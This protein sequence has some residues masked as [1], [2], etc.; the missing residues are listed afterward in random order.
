MILYFVSF[1]SVLNLI[2]FVGNLILSP[3][4]ASDSSIKE[5]FYYSVVRGIKTIPLLYYTDYVRKDV[6]KFLMENL[7]WKNPG[8]HYFDYL[9]QPLV[10]NVMRTKFNINCRIYNYSALVRSGQMDRGVSLENSQSEYVIEDPQVISLCIKRLGLTQEQFDEIVAN[11]TKIIRDYPN[12]Y[13]LSRVLRPV[14]WLL[15]KMHFISA[16]AYDKHF[17]CGE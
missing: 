13:A 10:T 11:P 1:F 6:D 17:N 16:S 9:Y 4:V 14:I 3:F 2:L 5:M 8:P 7:E 12:N 15:A